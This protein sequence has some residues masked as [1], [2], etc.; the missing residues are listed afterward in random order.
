MLGTGL[1]FPKSH[2]DG[3][4][5]GISDL[6]TICNSMVIERAGQQELLCALPRLTKLITIRGLTR[7]SEERKAIR[8]AASWRAP[9]RL[10]IKPKATGVSV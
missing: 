9:Q 7:A 8:I 2:Q 5:L 4:V 10:L 1:V 3:S 6:A